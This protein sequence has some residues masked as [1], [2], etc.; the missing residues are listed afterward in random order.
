MCYPEFTDPARPPVSRELIS[1]SER[2]FELCREELESM[3]GREGCIKPLIRHF[4]AAFREALN[5]RDWT[6]SVIGAC[7]GNIWIRQEWT[8]WARRGAAVAIW[9]MGN[10]GTLAMASIVC[11]TVS[12]V[13]TL[14]T[15]A[16]NAE[17]FEVKVLS[18][19]FRM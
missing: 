4:N 13:R 3:G 1:E 11:Y 8:T 15:G 19:S 6:E 17:A 5:R 16:L 18:D 7:V 9:P 14:L 12:S 10:G 2:Y